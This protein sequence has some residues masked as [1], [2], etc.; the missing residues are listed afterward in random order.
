MAVAWGAWAYRN[1]MVFDNPWSS[2]VVG[3]MGFVKLVEDYGKYKGVVG[4]V[5]L[6]AII[7]N[8]EGKIVVAAV[9]K[10]VASDSVKL[11]EAM[12]ARLGIAMAKRL[13]ISSD[14]F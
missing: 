14:Q 2:S 6:G 5:G 11:A 3:V 10:C 8:E 13:L 12:A 1:S 7:R 4:G 9:N